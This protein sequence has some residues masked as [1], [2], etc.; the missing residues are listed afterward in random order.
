MITALVILA[1]AL[2]LA[3]AGLGLFALSLAGRIM[4]NIDKHLPELMQRE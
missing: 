1:L 4:I 2:S 3:S